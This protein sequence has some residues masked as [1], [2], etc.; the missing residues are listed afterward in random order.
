MGK[1][2]ASGPPDEKNLEQAALRYLERYSSSLAGLRRVLRRRIRRA[3]RVGLGEVAAG[4]AL[5]EAVL[6]RLTQSGLLDD[7]RY[8]EFR[9]ASLAR[10]G[11]SLSAIRHD[12]RVRGVAPPLV[13]AALAALKQEI[14][15]EFER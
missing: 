10:R 4:D 11:A 9:A 7:A 12:L 3:A 1:S 15:G 5:V 14:G 6:G 8:A 13:E 2:Q